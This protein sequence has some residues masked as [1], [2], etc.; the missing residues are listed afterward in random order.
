MPIVVTPS[1]RSTPLVQYWYLIT[2]L[3][4]GANA[5]SLPTVPQQ[6]SFPPLGD[7]TPT[8]V[9]CYPY[10]A[11]AVGA[12]VTPDLTTISNSSGNITFTLYTDG[13]T[14]VLVGVA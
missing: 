3:T 12:V 1:N 7:W 2:G 9:Y 4:N 14:N 5:I 13:A 10:N 8:F 11:G 6:G